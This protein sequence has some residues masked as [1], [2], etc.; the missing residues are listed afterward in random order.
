MKKTLYLVFL[1]F[2]LIFQLS[3]AQTSGK[4]SGKIID[5]KNGVPLVG[6]NI[7]VVQTQSGTSADK[8][9]YFNVINVSPGKYSIRIMMIGY[10]SIT[11]EDVIVSVNR[12]TS[13]DIEMNQSVIEG[14]EVVIYASKFSRKKDQTSTM[15]NISSCTRKLFFNYV[16][17]KTRQI[18]RP[19]NVLVVF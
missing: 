9:G 6:A 1:I 7:I 8:D 11:I 10:E 3:N 15:K 17:E 13:L 18:I 14:Q 16:F 5:K 4:I 2:V 19:D 12:T